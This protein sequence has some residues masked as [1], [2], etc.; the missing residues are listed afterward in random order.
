MNAE[1]SPTP[2]NLAADLRDLVNRSFDT[3]EMHEI[4]FDFGLDY[5]DIPGRG[6]GA[7]IVEMVQIL[8]RQ[9]RVPEFIERCQALRPRENW[10]P[11]LE[12]AQREPLSFAVDFGQPETAVSQPT[13]P[14]APT[15]LQNRNLLIGIGA[16][17]V[18]AIVVAVLLLNGNNDGG[19]ISDFG[20]DTGLLEKIESMV[21][22]T[23][24]QTQFQFDTAMAG[25]QGSGFQVE[26]IDD[27]A[28]VILAPQSTLL[29]DRTFR[30]GQGILLDFKMS[31]VDDTNPPV[32][33]ILQNAQNRE[34][35]TRIITLE[36]VAQPHSS[37]IENGEAL[38][39]DQF[40]RNTTLQPNVDYTMTMGFDENGRFLASIFGYSVSTQEDARFIHE[41]PAE[42][43]NDTWWF[44]IDTGDQ[45]TVTLLG[46]WEFNF[47]TVK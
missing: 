34:D 43:T 7:K 44:A 12:A 4:A 22:N 27:F 20:G 21:S 25:W 31:A 35:A 42:W 46:G 14:A 3:N 2:T 11:L 45:G 30:P 29:R 18:V 15:L 9:Q 13:P 47:D 39:A 10:T 5:D 17:V 19:S 37:A 41:Q 33:F 1:S 8:A 23:Q 6:K 28:D 24:P 26:F 32:T 36:A 40:A 16:L 38:G